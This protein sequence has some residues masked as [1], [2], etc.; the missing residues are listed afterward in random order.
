[1]NINEVLK[2]P[3]YSFIKEQERLG[4]NIEF[5]TFGGSISYGLN[6]PTSD[7]D[8][9]GICSPLPRDYLSDFIQEPHPNDEANK[10]VLIKDGRFHQ[11]MDPN[12]DTVIYNVNKYIS[13]INEMN[14][15]TLEMLG[16]LPEH[17]AYVSDV[18]RLILDSKDIF[19]TKKAYFKFAG[20]ARDQLTRL[21]NALS[22]KATRL[23]QLL[24]TI[25][26]IQRSYQHLE[27]NFPTF[28]RDMIEFYIVDNRENVID[29]KA[30]TAF[31]STME[32]DEE[33]VR[34]R[35]S[36]ADLS[37]AEL[38]F[39]I[40][41]DGI[42]P[43][44]FKGVMKHVFDVINNFSQHLG[45]RNHKKDEAHED[46]HASHLVRLQK[47]AKKIL[48]NHTIET[49]CGDDIEELLD[50]KNGKYRLPNGKYSPVFFQKINKDMEELTNLYNMSTLPEKPDIERVR[51]LM[52]Q[53]NE[54]ILARGGY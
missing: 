23:D 47:T 25:S 53:V 22:R 54:I 29:M 42:S 17:Y 48:V 12:T 7:V 41:M 31:F 49:Y 11:Y 45:H 43:D 9:R 8:I 51:A 6:T 36:E 3:E 38:R 35:L 32:V 34:S 39:N 18:G 40:K 46:K 52:K 15:N 24:Q 27:E 44:D 21:E 5:L 20:Y 28:K 2:R 30:T 19:V 50:I 26:V 1:M 16:C 4:K 14:P 33:T 37:N 10:D 13:L